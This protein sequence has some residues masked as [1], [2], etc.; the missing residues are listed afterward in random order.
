MVIESIIPSIVMSRR[1]KSSIKLQLSWSA[2]EL[3]SSCKLTHIL[4]KS[5]SHSSSDK[6]HHSK[7]KV[8]ELLNSSILGKT[9][10]ARRKP[11][12]PKN[13]EGK[14][15]LMNQLKMKEEHFLMSKGEQKDDITIIKCK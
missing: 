15:W 7:V 3:G 11:N 2:L 8:K 14:I 5:N 6:N 12:S 13:N 1:S 9:K 10:K 4:R